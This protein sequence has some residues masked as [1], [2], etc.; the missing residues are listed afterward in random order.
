MRNFGVSLF[1]ITNLEGALRIS[2]G[3]IW[4][5]STAI[6]NGRSVLAV[7]IAKGRVSVDVLFFKFSCEKKR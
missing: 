6:K 7:E 3:G 4:V 1:D 2:L 5:E